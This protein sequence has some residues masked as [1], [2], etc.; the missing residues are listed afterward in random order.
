MLALP[1]TITTE[2]NFEFRCEKIYFG[3]A[4]HIICK[5]KKLHRTLSGTIFV[6][7]W[8]QTKTNKFLKRII[9]QTY[10]RSQLVQPYFTYIK[11]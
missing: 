7:I 3:L 11:I 8:W 4:Y 10:N 5:Y 2:K 1:N 9:G 6:S